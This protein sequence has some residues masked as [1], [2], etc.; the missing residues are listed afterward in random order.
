MDVLHV[1][2]PYHKPMVLYP[3]LSLPAVVDVALGGRSQAVLQASPS[4]A[5]AGG[6]AVSV[7][8]QASAGMMLPL[9]AALLKVS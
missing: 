9:L 2:F 1:H 6:R 7:A 8:V 4:S 3:T 5:Q